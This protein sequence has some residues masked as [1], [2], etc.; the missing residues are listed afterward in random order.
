MRFVALHLQAPMMSFGKSIVDGLHPTDDW[1]PPSWTTGIIANGLGYDYSEFRKTQALQARLQFAM[2]QDIEGGREWDFQTAKIQNNGAIWPTQLGWFE[3]RRQGYGEDKDTLLISKEFIYG[4]EYHMVVS[5][6]EGD[7]PTLEEIQRAI[8][9]PA[10]PLFLGRKC[11]PPSV[12]LYMPL[13]EAESHWEALHKIPLSPHAKHAS[14]KAIWPLEEG[15]QHRDRT[16]TMSAGKDWQNNVHLGRLAM[17]EGRI[18]LKSGGV[19]CST[20]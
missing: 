12:P 3:G 10:R 14:P 2:R 16:I 17:N 18:H 20:S 6:A 7:G 5:L 13:I 15:I 8:E 4:A 11:C 1:A 19:S 9:K